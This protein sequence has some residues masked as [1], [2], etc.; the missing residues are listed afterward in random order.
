[1]RFMVYT[2]TISYLTVKRVTDI[3]RQR[4]KPLA[5][6]HCNRCVVGFIRRQYAGCRLIVLV[7]AVRGN[8]LAAAHRG[9]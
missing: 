4:L 9:A 5:S 3:A 1:M 6:T 7:L 2:I 8:R